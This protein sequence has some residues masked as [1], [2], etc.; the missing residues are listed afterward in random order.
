MQSKLRK[1]TTTMAAVAAFAAL[2]GAQVQCPGGAEA[3]PS[4]EALQA[5]LDA[6]KS[7]ICR[8]AAGTP[9]FAPPAFCP[10]IECPCFR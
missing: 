5:E 7:E 9:G 4:L 8:L 2:L 6:A 3:R 1:A 10:V